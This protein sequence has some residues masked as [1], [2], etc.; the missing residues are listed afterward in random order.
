MTMSSRM[1]M[2][3]HSKYD[4]VQ[5]YDYGQMSLLCAG[6]WSHRQLGHFAVS[7]SFLQLH[8]WAF[9]PSALTLDVVLLCV[10]GTATGVVWFDRQWL[11]ILSSPPPEG[12]CPYAL[13]LLL[14]ICMQVGLRM[15]S[16]KTFF[17]DGSFSF[18]DHL[19]YLFFQLRIWCKVLGAYPRN[20]RGSRCI[21]LPP[22]NKL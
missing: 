13:R 18:S 7:L 1:T 4:Y 10:P 16:A 8:V 14:M 20:V 19:Q 6:P 15:W 22:R 5:S 21:A 9:R 17:G 12:A 11:H 3:S 2:A